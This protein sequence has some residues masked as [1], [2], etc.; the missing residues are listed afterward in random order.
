MMTLQEA[1]TRAPLDPANPGRSAAEIAGLLANEGQA[2][3]RW[4]D[5]ISH[6]GARDPEAL[7]VTYRE[8]PVQ[9][10]AIGGVGLD[11]EALEKDTFPFLAALTLA[12]AHLD[13]EAGTDDLPEL[14][15][16]LE[17]K[18]YARRYR[19]RQMRF[20]LFTLV[21]SDKAARDLLVELTS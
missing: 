1:L 16:G 4:H 18:E 12:Q 20:A 19:L 2:L 9:P 3:L 14:E 6:R 15:E 5:C 13:H 21:A 7:E 17:Y 11:L 8:R 10:I